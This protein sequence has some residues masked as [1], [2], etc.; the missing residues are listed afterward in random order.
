MIGRDQITA[1]K[2][3]NSAG[4]LQD[5]VKSPGREM[6]LLHG[7]LQQFL[8]GGFDVA[9]QFGAGETLESWRSR[10]AW[11]RV[12]IVAEKIH[13]DTLVSRCCKWGRA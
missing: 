13:K 1:G 5:T 7:C 2:V 12:R 9:G 6:E 8:G 11:T 10:A 3:G 4:Q